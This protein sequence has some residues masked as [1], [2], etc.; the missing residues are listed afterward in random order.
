MTLDRPFMIVLYWSGNIEY[1][2]GT[3]KGDHSTF[4]STNIVRN[5][6]GYEEFKDLCY[7]HVG[8]EKKSYKLNISLCYQFGGESSITRV[9]S[10]SSLE[11]MYYLA[12]NVENYRGQVFVKE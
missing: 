4:S 8:V 3:L 12:E 10:D 9:I 2:N 1:K 5:K 11:V 6:M 7:A